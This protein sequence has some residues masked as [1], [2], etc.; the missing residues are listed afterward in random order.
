[1]LS[2]SDPSN[3]SLMGLC[4]FKVVKSLADAWGTSKT[5]HLVITGGRSGIFLAKAIDQILFWL[6]GPKS[7][8]ESSMLHICFSDER[9]TSLEDPERYDTALIAGFGLCKS[10]IAFHRV[11][12]QLKIETVDLEV[13]AANH[14]AELDMKLGDQPFDA[15]AMRWIEPSLSIGDPTRIFT[16]RASL[17][18]SPK[19]SA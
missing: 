2:V 3:E 14:A 16:A 8:F 6:I 5:S 7:T 9:S 10:Q 1:M 11:D 17:L 4:A 15:R 12:A 19:A 13:A 18:I